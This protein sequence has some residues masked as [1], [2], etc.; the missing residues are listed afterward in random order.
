MKKHEITDSGLD[1]IFGKIIEQRPLLTDEQVNLLLT[2]PSGKVVEK[3]GKNFL[4]YFLKLFIPT[5]SVVLI[6]ILALIWL[7]PEP[8]R[9]E[10]DIEN[11]LISNQKIVV[12]DD[13]IQ[14][15]SVDSLKNFQKELKD[16][17]GNLAEVVHKKP[18]ISIVDI[19]SNFKKKPQ[20]FL[21]KSDRDT[22]IY[23][24]EG[25]LIKIKANSIILEKSGEL[26]SAVV[27]LE[28]EEY[29]KISDMIF[30]NLTTTSDKKMLETG[31]MIHISATAHNEKC[32]V[33]PGTAIEIGFP[34]SL[35]KDKMILFEGVRS[36]NLIDW[37]LENK[38]DDVKISNELTLIDVAPVTDS[39]SEVFFIVED[40]P[41][42]PGGEQAMRR[43]L[44]ENAIYPS[45]MLN[46]NIEGKVTVTFV[47]DSEGN[48]TN[49]RVVKGLDETLDKAAVYAVSNFPT[50]KPGKQRGRPV[51]VSYTISVNFSAPE[52][53]LN[54]E[55]INKSKVLEE[56]LKSF[57]YDNESAKFLSNSERNRK[58]EKNI[59]DGN[60][61]ET[62]VYEVNR[63]LFSSNRFGW[64]NCDRF[65]DENRNLTDLY[66]LN[67]K[68]KNTIVNVIFHR[69]KSLVPGNIESEKV[70][71]R[72]IPAGEKVTI[73]A[74]KAE[75]SEILLSVKEIVVT[76]KKDIIP[77]FQ[78]VT[79]ELLKNE[80]EK[81][82]K[83]HQ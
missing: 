63:Y 34:F 73:V 75:E 80:M 77:D 43:F 81:L 79:L 12:L 28:V 62:S 6:L 36:G 35:K 51:D 2:N 17:K 65:L 57:Q 5:V 68:P 69:F 30:A 78:K 56:K 15:K 53:E 72:N 29:Y 18:E 10:N 39:N 45:S 31:G 4:R 3:P 11:N 23:C 32:I 47:V 19:F 46:K 49:I 38:T 83:I 27:K 9:D 52:G 76:D 54:Q 59:G 61:K 25:T 50:W 66:I 26:K 13:S 7:K 42:F 71:F 20:V 64:L 74:V 48:T 21:I 70:V 40:M 67:E 37:K 24:K 22:S 1:K 41:E 82:D 60:F 44:K 14:M 55:E 58:F 16:S 33:K 8:G